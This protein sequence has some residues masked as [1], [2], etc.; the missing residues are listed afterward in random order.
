[1]MSNIWKA[2]AYKSGSL[3]QREVY[4]VHKFLLWN[5][6]AEFWVK[7]TIWKCT[8]NSD[9]LHHLKYHYYVLKRRNLFLSLWKLHKNNCSRKFA[10]ALSF[11]ISQLRL[12]FSFLFLFLNFS[13]LQPFLHCP[14]LP[15]SLGVEIIK[16]ILFLSCVL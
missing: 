2:F 15:Y 6:I 13:I 1:M 8:F 9:K 11:C 14:P 7:F 4:Y 3:T 5:L 10:K 16:E 12:D